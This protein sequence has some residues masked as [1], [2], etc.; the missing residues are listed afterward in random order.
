MPGVSEERPY[1]HGNLRAALLDAAGRGLRE[2][3]ADGLSLRDLAREVGVSHAAPRRHFP[4]RQALLDALAEDGFAHLDTAL[5]AALAGAGEGFSARVRA[6]M[7]AYIR[8]ATENAAL[9]EVMY[10]GKHRPGATRLVEAAR[11]P[12]GMMA[13]LITEGQE[14]GALPAG[15]PERVGLVL[16]ATMQGIASLI[17]GDLVPPDMLDDLV[18]TTVEQ[19][20]GGTRPQG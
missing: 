14:Q 9:L 13:D 10:A 4:D 20:V 5:R 12:F 18:E 6:A 7:T 16:F 1:H 11:A 17:N 2:R 3:G 8:F 15:D 19:F